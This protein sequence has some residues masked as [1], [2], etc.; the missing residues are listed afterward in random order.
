[1]TATV[2][3][4]PGVG[5]LRHYDVAQRRQEYLAALD[6]YLDPESGVE[7]V[8]FA[9]NSD[10]DLSPMRELSEHKGAAG[11]FETLPVPRADRVEPRSIGEARIVRYAM[12]HSPTLQGL[13]PRQH[14]WKVTGRY[15]LRNLRRLIETAPDTDLYI[16]VRRWP[17][18]W[19]DTYAYAF[20]RAGFERY[21]EPATSAIE[22]DKSP[23]RIGEKTVAREIMNFLDAG[24]PIVPRFKYEPRVDGVRG[25]DLVS[26][27]SP[28]Q[29]VKYA[30]RVAVR[31]LA[32]GLWI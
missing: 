5:G 3:P 1:M 17:L 32:P 22:H 18:L 14:V 2:A 20:T 29:R 8:V 21:V 30:T 26:Y 28:K 10:S 12:E 13:L 27:G 31:R 4:P 9:E 6:V 7:R 19:C 16:N 15:I 11:R 23:D 25:S 24:A